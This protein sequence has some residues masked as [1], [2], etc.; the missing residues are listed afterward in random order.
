MSFLEICGAAFLI[1]TGLGT[2]AGL[3]AAI[4][5]EDCWWQKAL[6]RA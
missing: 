5:P 1:V 4:S 3:L 2:L 6:P